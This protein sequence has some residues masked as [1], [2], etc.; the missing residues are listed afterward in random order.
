MSKYSDKRTYYAIKHL[1]SGNMNLFFS[2]DENYPVKE[3]YGLYHV[4]VAEQRRA[5]M[6]HPEDW[7]VIVSPVQNDSC[8]YGRR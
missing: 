8:W 7:E 6:T 5:N 2:D 3:R 4:S 1:P